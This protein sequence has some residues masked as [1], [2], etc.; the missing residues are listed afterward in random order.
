MA[1]ELKKQE[2]PEAILF[3]DWCDKNEERLYTSALKNG[4]DMPSNDDLYKQFR[5]SYYGELDE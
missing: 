4:R 5:I 1:D 2:V 3:K